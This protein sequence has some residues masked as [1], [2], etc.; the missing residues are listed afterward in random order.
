M[1]LNPWVSI[2]P[3]TIVVQENALIPEAQ[4]IL[5]QNIIQKLSVQGNQLV[6]IVTADKL[7]SSGFYR[8]SLN[9]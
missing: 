4:L 3:D 8:Q 2:K 7:Q 5:K 9:L 1:G 6:G